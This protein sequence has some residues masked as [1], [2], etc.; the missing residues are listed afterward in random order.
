MGRLLEKILERIGRPD[1]LEILSR[2]MSLGELTSVMLEVFRMRARELSPHQLLRTYRENRFVHPGQVDPLALREMELLLFQLGRD[3]GF[4]PRELSPVAPFGVV[5]CYGKIDQN[6][7]LTALR[8]TE[9][10]AD[11]ANVLGLQLAEESHCGLG[12]LLH[13]CGSQRVIRTQKFD[14][15]RQ[16]PHFSL[17][18]CV[19]LL[20]D[21]EPEDFLEVVK[22]HLDFQ[23]SACHALGLRAI[24]FVFASQQGGC[25]AAAFARQILEGYPD[26]K[27][28]DEPP[29]SGSYYQGYRI[30][31]DILSS[32]TWINIGDMGPVDWA[33][34]L[35][36]QSRCQL[37][38]S[39]LG[40]DRLIQVARD[41]GRKTTESS[42]ANSE[43]L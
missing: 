8:G 1:L 29:E 6:N 11:P 2:G 35:L 14:G 16:F 23:R 9:L 33:A 38:T 37:L 36:G 40:V 27:F 15:P 13:G 12:P 20:R 24:R 41:S 5:S 22:R 17:F 19:S 10:V 34:E 7:V 28:F 26:L 4:I 42:V 18:A 39:G 25:S 32:G 3:M 31:L 30:R 43:E 21:G